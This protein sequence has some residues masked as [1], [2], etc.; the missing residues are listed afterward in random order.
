MDVTDAPPAM[1]H[2][3]PTCHRS[4]RRFKPGGVRSRP[5][6]KCP[7]CGA[8]ERHRF[9]SLLLDGLAPTLAH[10]ATVVDIAPSRYT[11]DHLEGFVPGRYIR[12]DL[13][14]AADGRAVDVQASLTGLPFADGSVDLVLCYHVLEHVPDDATAMRELA[15]VLTPGGLALVQVPFRPAKATDEDP[16]APEAERIERFGQADH[17]RWYGG[18]FEDRL[19][20]AGLRGIRIQPRDVLGDDVPPFFGITPKESIW[21]LR[22][23]GD[24]EATVR[25]AAAPRNELLV[26]LHELAAG[27]ASGQLAA[28][29]R[30]NAALRD[31]VVRLR[32]ERD[33]VKA[34]RDRWRA[35]HERLTG[36]PV[37]RALAVPYRWVKRS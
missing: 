8:L 25:R 34:Q 12:V 30:D 35:R 21:L 24:Q 5:N 11:T 16:D 26:G 27:A 10:A 22:A 14:P 17:V 32:G 20:A 19:A 9:L 36:H 3:C 37:V 18:D 2:Y 1:A 7:S 6:A 28:L 33:R 29:E 23:A 4:V 15:R 31:D 13:D